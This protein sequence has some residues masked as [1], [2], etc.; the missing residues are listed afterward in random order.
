M[1]GYELICCIV[2]I[3]DASKTL[4]MARKYGV[5]DATIFI[6]R[7]TVH[8]RLLDLLGIHEVRREIMLMLVEDKYAAG[9]VQGLP[10][11]ME[12]HKPHHGILFS[13]PISRVVGEKSATRTKSKGNEGAKRMHSVI[14][15]VVER[16]MAE[17]VIDAANAAGARG[18]TIINAR[19][20]GPHEVQRLFSVEIEPEKE[21]V[22][23]VTKNE[24]K[25][26]IVESIITRMRIDQPGRG[27]M[28]VMDLNEVYGL[29]E[30]RG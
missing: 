30:D 18:G 9:V 21:A 15:V 24:N 23:I 29:H 3:G 11:D 19:G 10:I 14:Q 28:F 27:I 6:G 25:D 16:G 8:S 22:L 1:A 13:C 7:G 2:K 17:D 12:I 5:E 26:A 4:K 20:A